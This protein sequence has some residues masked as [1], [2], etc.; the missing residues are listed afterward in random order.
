[1]GTNASIFFI[2][3]PLSLSFLVRNSA[4]EQGPARC[5]FVWAGLMQEKQ[6]GKTTLFRKRKSSDRKSFLFTHGSKKETI[7]VKSSGYLANFRILR[8]NIVI[9]SVIRRRNPT[10]SEADGDSDT[11]PHPLRRDACAG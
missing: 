11:P 6:Q 5:F 9:Y 2:S 8:Y 10:E 4:P 7:L 3:T 1:M